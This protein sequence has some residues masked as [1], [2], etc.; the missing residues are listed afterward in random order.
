MSETAAVRLEGSLSVVDAAQQREQL[1]ALLDSHPGDLGLDLGH[2]EDVDTAGVQ[3][4][5]ATGRS[6][7]ERGHRLHLIAVSQAV[8]QALRS[9]GLDPRLCPLPPM[10][11][12]EH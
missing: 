5:L 1:L 12:G 4:L 10:D 11:A 3:L 6:L 2:I 7:R 8:Q 9:Y